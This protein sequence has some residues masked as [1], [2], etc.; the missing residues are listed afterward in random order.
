MP[1]VCGKTLDKPRK[2][3]VVTS[4]PLRTGLDKYWTSRHSMS[5]YLCLTHLFVLF[6][7][8][9]LY[10]PILRSFN[11]LLGRYTHFP[12]PLLLQRRSEN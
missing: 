6:L 8:T 7:Y 5:G 1:K 9:V 2:V 4:A 10:T 11:L 3:S 12:Q